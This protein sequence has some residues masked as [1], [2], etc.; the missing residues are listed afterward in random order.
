MFTPQGGGF[1]Y[2]VFCSDTDKYL[3]ENPE[4]VAVF[5]AGNDG[6]QGQESILSPGLAKNAMA[7]GAVHN[8]PLSMNMV[9]DF[10]AQ[11]PANDGRIKPDVLAPGQSMYVFVV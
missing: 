1:W 3:Y 6:N 11:G 5:A 9:S 7:I 2:D 4:F 10:S 8:D